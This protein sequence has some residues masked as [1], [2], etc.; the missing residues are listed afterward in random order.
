MKNFFPIFVLMLAMFSIQSG[1]SLAKMLFPI[2]G[3]IG[4]TTLRLFFATL[5]LGLFWRPWRTSIH[6]KEI[7]LLVYYGMSLGFMNFLFY[8]AIE[9]IPLGIAVAIEFIGPLT[10]AVMS[11]K[12]LLDYL[13]ALLAAIG[14]LLILPI[15]EL[16]SPIDPVGVLFAFGA[17]ICWALY[18][19]AGQKAGKHLSAGV[20]TSYGMLIATI[21]VL[22]F[23]IIS[24][25]PALL[26]FSLL[27]LALGVA[28]FSS[29]IPYSLE[30]YALKNMPRK[31]FGIL[32]SLEPAFAAMSGFFFLHESLNIVQWMAIF[33]IMVSS[34]GVSLTQGGSK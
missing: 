29:A 10:L 33:L 23:G 14:I 5:I 34:V 28:L 8:L 6:R 21:C 25:G 30:M 31:E 2:V 17:A 1:A 15:A 24:S 4:T 19:I 11:S 18:I 13:W 9:R 26:N 27:P 32:M 22:P 12:K 20:V 7:K 3:S 16:S